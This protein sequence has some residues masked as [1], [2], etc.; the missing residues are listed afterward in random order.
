MEG[1]H[2]R[3]AEHPECVPVERLAGDSARHDRAREALA[4]TNGLGEME[5]AATHATTAQAAE[6]RQFVV[7]RLPEGTPRQG[8]DVMNTSQDHQRADLE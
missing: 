1:L 2:S 5:V 6:A 3:E 4:D 7:I 8:T